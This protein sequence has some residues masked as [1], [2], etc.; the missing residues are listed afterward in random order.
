MTT[1][2]STHARERHAGSEAR[3]R[4]RIWPGLKPIVVTHPDGGRREHRRRA[5]RDDVLGNIAAIKA[6]TADWVSAANETSRMA[7][8]RRLN[9]SKSPSCSR[10]HGALPVYRN[11]FRSCTR[12]GCRVKSHASYSVHR[13]GPSIRQAKAS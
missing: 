6:V 3:L 9:T 12:M 2:H 11:G 4:R 13:T 8:A 5:A 7:R 10:A 1:A